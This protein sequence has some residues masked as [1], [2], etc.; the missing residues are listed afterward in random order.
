MARSALRD[1]VY[2]E[3][4]ALTADVLRAGPNGRSPAER[5]EAWLLH[6]EP[7]V[8]RCLNVVADLR[9]AGPLDLARLSVAVREVRN[10]I[11]AAAAP[12]PEGR[13]SSAEQAVSPRLY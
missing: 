10:L 6:N 5:I 12:E 11:N 13:V 2:A 3:Q 8:E 1:D 4:A 9:T 7:A